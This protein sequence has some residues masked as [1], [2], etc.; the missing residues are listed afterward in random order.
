MSGSKKIHKKLWNIHNWVGL[1]AGVFIAILSVSGVVALFK[2]EIDEA[3]NAHYFTIDS[4]NTVATYHPDIIQLI[5][6]LKLEYGE[7]NL[8]SI[9]P[10]LDTSKNWIINFNVVEREPYPVAYA[11]QIFFN[12]Y[13]GKV[14]GVRDRF[15]TFSHYIRHLHVRLFNGLLGR[16]WVGIGGIALL[17]ST[18][19]G[20]WIY[21]G[22]MKRQFFG[23]IR[24]K[25]LKLK[26]ADYHKI[27]GMTTLL[28]NLM[29]AVTGAWLG[30]QAILQPVLLIK[31]PERYQQTEKPLSKEEDIAYEV[32]YIKAFEIS[33]ALF[34]DLIS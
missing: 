16:W 2:V 10:S 8:S 28:F 4:Q 12:P 34:P 11:Y 23:A 30:L 20:L 25:N 13:T 3:I 7:A 33:R 17:I 19:T 27:I 31:S 5:D 24:N 18:I 9:T 32:D 29:I 14:V 21:G 26:S 1:Y 15:K 22:F 6:S